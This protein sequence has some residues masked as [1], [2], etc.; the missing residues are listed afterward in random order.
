MHDGSIDDIIFVNKTDICYA[1]IND[2]FV[3][4]GYVIKRCVLY[5]QCRHGSVYDTRALQNDL[6]GKD[7]IEL[8]LNTGSRVQKGKRIGHQSIQNRKT[9]IYDAST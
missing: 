3:D 4:D 5:G 1:R 6:S 2:K 9:E 7:I 8:I